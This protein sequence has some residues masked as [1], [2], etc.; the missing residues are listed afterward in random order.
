MNTGAYASEI[1]RGGLQSVPTGR[2]R[3]RGPA[4]CPG[5]LLFRRIV[6]P[7]A[8]RQA[9][10]AYGSEIILMVKA[11]SLA[12]IITMMEVTGLAAKADL[13]N[14][15]RRGS[16]HR[17]WPDLSRSST[18]PSRASSWPSN[19][20]FPH[21]CDARPLSSHVW[22]LPMSNGAPNLKTATVQAVSVDNLR[23]S[24]GSLEVLKGVSL[25]ANDG[26]VISILGASGS[27][28]STMLR[29]INMLEVPDSGEIRIGG[30]EIGIKRTRRGME[31]ADRAQV[32]RIRSRVA[33]VFQSFNLWSHMTILE[34]VIE[35]PIHV[36]KRPRAEC[37]ARSRGDSRKR[38]ASSTSATNI[39]RTSR[40]GSSSA[41]PSRGRSPCDPQVMLFDEP[42]SALDPELVG[43]VLRVM[44]ALAEEGRTMLVVTHEMGFARDVS[45]RVMFLHQGNGRRRRSAVGRVRRAEI[46]ALQAV[47]LQ[48]PLRRSTCAYL[49]SISRTSVSGCASFSGVTSR[50]PGRG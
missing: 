41:P 40:A 31:P 27:G 50:Y 38:S 11:T 5:F 44:R 21:I 9:L 46:R 34:N 28:K 13:A 17:R 8:V 36:Q 3:R 15:P 32:D 19:G 49:R 33:M 1:I 29:C 47:H 30:E 2:S 12:S 39:R 48:P 23:K 37:I 25:S 42:T 18:S 6:F 10:P 22:K 26:D 16:L 14:L 35:A 24:F 45:N 7:I 4:A 43:E 20:G